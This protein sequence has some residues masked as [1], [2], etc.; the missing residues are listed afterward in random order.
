MSGSDDFFNYK[1]FFPFDQV[2]GQFGIV[3]AVDFILLIG[4]ESTSVEDVVNAL[5]AIG[6]F[7]LEVDSSNGVDNFK[8][9]KALGSQFLQGVVGVD[10]F[11]I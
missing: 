7:Q 8:W 3:G 1:F 4:C 5:P 9:P 2:W 11:S 6:Q 10:V